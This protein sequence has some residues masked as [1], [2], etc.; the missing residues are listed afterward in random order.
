MSVGSNL[1]GLYQAE[2]R[3]PAIFRKR[4]IFGNEL[5]HEMAMLYFTYL[6]GQESGYITDAGLQVEALVSGLTSAQRKTRNLMVLYQG[7][8]DD[9]GSEPSEPYFVLAGFVSTYEKWR[10]FS[11]E[12]NA[13]LKLSPSLNYFKMSEAKHFNGEFSRKNGWNEE[14]CEERIGILSKIIENYALLRISTSINNQEY[15][16]YIRSLPATRR[17]LTTDGPYALLF[18]Q[19]IFHMTNSGSVGI[20]EP[21]DFIFDEQQGYGSAALGH[22]DDMKNI[23]NA[24]TPAHMSRLLG[25]RPIFRDEK[26]FLP[27]QAADLYAWLVR[28]HLTKVDAEID[29]TLASI[30]TSVKP[31]LHYHFHEKRLAKMRLGLQATANQL[32]AV[33]PEIKLQ[34]FIEDKATRKA[35]RGF[36]KRMR[37]KGKK[38]TS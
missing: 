12:W 30:I 9:S 32:F 1:R 8:I 31:Y 26:H 29:P 34:P 10:E 15:N 22:W 35:H 37:R 28:N 11:E 3:S 6:S 38:I 17:D 5:F 16:N 33:K 18:S 19:I 36:E 21:C 27:L 20:S 14:L 13:A 4:P 23:V 24:Q 2:N 7:F 25:S